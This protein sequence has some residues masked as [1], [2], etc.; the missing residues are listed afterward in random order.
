MLAI[1]SGLTLGMSADTQ[2][3]LR[4]IDYASI[5]GWSEDNHAAALQAFRR[6][7]LEIVERG[8]AFRREVKFGGVRQ[9]WSGVCKRVDEASQPRDFFEKNFTP[10]V[11]SDPARP[12]G[13]FTG[14]Y[15]PEAPGSRTQSVGYPVPIYRKPD[16]LVAF[17]FAGQQETGLKYGRV[18]DGHPKPYSTRKEIEQGALARRGLE[19]VW[20][21]DWAD[22][23]FIH[24]QGSGRIRLEDGSLVRL[25]YAAK[26]GQPYTGVGGLLAD[27]GVFSREQ[28]S[29]QATRSWMAKNYNAARQLMWE[30]RSFIF[31][32]E[33]EVAD[34]EL[35]PPGAQ[36]VALTPERSLAVDRSIWAFGT[37]V[38]LDTMT[39]SGADGSSQQFRHLLVAQD[40]GTAIRGHVR[41]DIF[42]GAGERAAFIAGHLK[43]PGKM[44]VLLPNDLAE[45]LLAAQ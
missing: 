10:L 28:M 45:Q 29:M 16:D 24:I 37:P 26:S 25:A 8:R 12:E 17:D 2:P 27:R 38:W 13:M 15:E 21:K 35:G 11:V 9:Q 3:I 20:L 5:Q 43:S 36:Q 33:V 39:P 40:T 1:V 30:N 18:I 32:R 42:W 4:K 23:F 6:S 34:P 14:Y 19:I 31:F 44:I 41:G 22:A 7:C